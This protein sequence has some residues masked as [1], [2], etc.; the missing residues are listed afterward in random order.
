MKG[1]TITDNFTEKRK[2]NIIFRARIFFQDKES[3][4]QNAG[5]II[6]DVSWFWQGCFLINWHRKGYYNYTS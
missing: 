4:N 1:N 2:W 6:K 3:K 5:N